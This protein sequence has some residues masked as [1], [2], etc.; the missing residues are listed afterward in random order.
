[1][2]RKENSLALA[3]MNFNEHRK[4]RQL[5]SS[6]LWTIGAKALVMSEKK[7]KE[8][9][10][11]SLDEEALAKKE[12]VLEAD[13]RLFKR[14]MSLPPGVPV[15]KLGAHGKSGKAP[16]QVHIQFA[17]LNTGAYGIVWKSAILKTTK[18]FDLTGV[19]EV[20]N[21]EASDHANGDE[22]TL[23][24]GETTLSLKFSSSHQK[25]VFAYA[26]SHIAHIGC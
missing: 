7:S 13:T 24:N 19:T 9:A 17:V 5:A 4:M 18:S 2:P 6:Y 8:Q 12:M 22:I 21:E 16:R 10:L 3:V 15:I 11:L 25:D 1:M 20:I 26:I 14:D 23:D